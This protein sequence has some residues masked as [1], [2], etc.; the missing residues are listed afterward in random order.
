[1][2]KFQE[3]LRLSGADESELTNA[4]SVLQI[5]V[6]LCGDMRQVLS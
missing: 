5:A 6:K 3:T 1:M 2:K 4:E